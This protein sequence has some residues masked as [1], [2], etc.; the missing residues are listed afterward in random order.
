MRI[1]SEVSARGTTARLTALYLLFGICWVLASDLVVAEFVPFKEHFASQVT[2]GLVFVALTAA[3]FALIVH[4]LA[5]QTYQTVEIQRRTLRDTIK[6]LSMALEKR[7]PYTA[8][9]TSLVAQLAVA[10]GARMDLSDDRL[11]EIE[12]GALVH[13][14]GKVA[15]PSDL[16][17]K[18]TRLTEAEFELIKSHPQAGYEILCGIEYGNEVPLIVRDHHERLDGSGYPSGLKGDEISIGAQIV[19]VADVA[20][21]MTSHRPYRPALGAEAAIAELEQGSG[22]LYNADAVSICRSLLRDP[23]FSLSL[24]PGTVEARTARAI[25]GARGGRPTG[26]LATDSSG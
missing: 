5:R 16:L 24:Q 18:P 2:K 15:V 10:I 9:H 14:I 26:R 7:D 12:L 8:R 19:A 13:D 21:S 6:A 1:L 25:E 4:A 17:T 22:W 3:L 11:F 20:E 23:E